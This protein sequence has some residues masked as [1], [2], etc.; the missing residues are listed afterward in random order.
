[1]NPGIRHVFS[2]VAI[3][4]AHLHF[5]AY[6]GTEVTNGCLESLVGSTARLGDDTLELIDLSLGTA[7][8][9]ELD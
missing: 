1:M 5:S 9:T 4:L 6:G 8:G 7:E 3:L 2:A